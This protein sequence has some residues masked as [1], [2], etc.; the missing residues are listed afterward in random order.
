V[1]QT[2]ERRSLEAFAQKCLELFAFFKGGADSD[3]ATRSSSSFL[4]TRRTLL[5]NFKSAN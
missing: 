5:Q 1:I 2:P 3:F 4:V